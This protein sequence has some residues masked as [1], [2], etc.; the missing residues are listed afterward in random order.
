MIQIALLSLFLVPA[1][2]ADAAP[3]FDVQTFNA[4]TQ[5]RESHANALETSV[6]RLAQLLRSVLSGYPFNTRQW[7]GGVDTLDHRVEQTSTCRFEFK[8][9]VRGEKHGYLVSQTQ[10]RI[11]FA[12]AASADLIVPPAADSTPIGVSLRLNAQTPVRKQSMDGDS[13]T[14]YLD[15]LEWTGGRRGEPAPGKYQELV[16]ILNGLKRACAKIST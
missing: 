3:L 16:V 13:T 5:I 2:H 6:V 10:T 15:R 14:V 1:A 11:D 7:E 8:T 12:R 9:T 4:V